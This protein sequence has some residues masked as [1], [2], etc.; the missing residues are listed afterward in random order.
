VPFRWSA[1]Y[2]SCC[3][4]IRKCIERARRQRRKSR[5]MY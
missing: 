1:Y 5:G 2:P 4:I 3:N